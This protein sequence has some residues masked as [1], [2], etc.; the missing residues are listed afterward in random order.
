MEVVK[1][2]ISLKKKALIIIGVICFIAFLSSLGKSGNGVNN[3]SIRIPGEQN[4]IK[5]GDVLKTEYF[6]I[7][8]N[9]MKVVKYVNTG[10]Q[11]SDLKEEPG[12]LFLVINATY[13]NT[14]SESRMLFDGSIWINYNGKDYEFDKS[15]PVMAEGWGLMLDQINPLTSKTT[16][17]V[18]KIPEEIKGDVYWQPGRSNSDEKIHLSKI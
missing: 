15:E 17:L 10:N 1:K 8:A 12:N 7:T 16:N 5:I 11:F 3:S 18:Y 14:D 9:K 4:T 13:K 2:K 6:D